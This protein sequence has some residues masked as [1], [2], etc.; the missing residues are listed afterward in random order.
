MG[1]I[2]LT[3]KGILPLLDFGEILGIVY[4]MRETERMFSWMDISYSY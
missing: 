3:W 2:K 4:N 1:Q